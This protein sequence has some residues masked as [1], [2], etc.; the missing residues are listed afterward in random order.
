MVI[1]IIRDWIERRDKQLLC[2]L[3]RWILGYMFP[4]FMR[5]SVPHTLKCAIEGFHEVLDR[6]GIDRGA[7]EGMAR[8]HKN[9]DYIQ[10]IP[11]ICYL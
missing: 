6:I 1:D 11:Y 3:Y 4:A 8:Y 5:R 10:I 2:S 7:V 9:T